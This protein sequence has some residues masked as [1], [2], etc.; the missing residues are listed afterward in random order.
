MKKFEISYILRSTAWVMPILPIFWI[1]NQNVTLESYISLVSFFSIISFGIDFPVSFLAD[2]INLKKTY[3][4]GLAFFGLSF[5]FPIIFK[6]IF[7]YILYLSF[8]LLANGMISG[9]DIALIKN[10]VPQNKFYTYFSSLTKKFY[11]LT[12]PFMFLGALF[13]LF[14]P[15][16]PLVIQMVSII[17]CIIIINSLPDSFNKNNNKSTL[18]LADNNPDW[19]IEFST[20]FFLLVLLLMIVFSVFN[21]VM[22]FQNRTT[23]ILIQQLGKYSQ[24]IT[25]FISLVFIS[26]GNIFSA[27]GASKLINIFPK[28]KSFLLYN[29]LLIFISCISLFLLSTKN[30]ILI[31]TGYILI[32]LCKGAYRPYYQ[33]IISGL[34][35]NSLLKARW[36]SFFTISSTIIVSSLSTLF[37]FIT[38]KIHVI[39]LLWGGTLLVFG[40]LFLIFQFKNKFFKMKLNTKSS[41]SFSNLFKIYDF[42]KNH[43][44]FE[45]INNYNTLFLDIDNLQNITLKS[46][47]LIENTSPN[48]Q[49][50]EFVEGN[51]LSDITNHD[52]K[53]ILSII[54]KDMYDKKNLDDS[55]VYNGVLRIG[56]SLNKKC[57]EYC[58]C[59]TFSHGDLHPANILIKNNNEYCLVDWDNG[60][61]NSR[62]LDEFSL[63]FHPNLNISMQERRK[64]LNNFFEFHKKNCSLRKLNNQEQTSMINTLI[65]EKINDLTNIQD[66]FYIDLIKKYKNLI[67]EEV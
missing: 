56:G 12:I 1:N 2:R 55:I 42:L 53:Y 14:N 19:K 45:K 16:L 5:L 34:Q 3:I 21:G 33:S 15:Y 63:I 35:P 39:Q 66:E 24:L 23:P 36:F 46:P 32:S 37:I 64:Y 65:L 20:S 41:S 50:W 48:N 49:I 40:L 54:L 43:I 27:F 26:I 29:F 22:N 52:Q 58:D 59:Y 57:F 44:Y 7:S 25:V 67:V 8:S 51:T 61:I 30:I 11:L 47:K 17:S 10:I 62:L 13:Y 9:V 31:F 6:G 38:N 4:V 60:S 28:K 18:K